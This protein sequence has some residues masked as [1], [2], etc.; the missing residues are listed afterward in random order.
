MLIVG[1]VGLVVVLGVMLGT[2]GHYLG[3]LSQAQTA[4]DSAALAAAPVTFRPFGSQGDPAAEAARLA[5]ANGARLV[6]CVCP[7]DRSW[8]ERVVKVEVVREVNLAVLGRRDVRAKAAAEF[9]PIDL[10]E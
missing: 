5:V 2:A 3:S 4:A 1:V 10:I 8:A 9:A 6:N 7:I